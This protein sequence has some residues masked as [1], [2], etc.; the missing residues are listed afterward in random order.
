MP[1]NL[2]RDPIQVSTGNDRKVHV[3]SMNAQ[4]PSSHSISPLLDVESTFAKV[5]TVQLFHHL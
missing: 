5:V 4:T 3:R 2:R 1:Y